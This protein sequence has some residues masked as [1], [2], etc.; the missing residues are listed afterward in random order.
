MIRSLLAAAAVTVAASFPATAE[1]LKFA[2]TDIE[3]LEALQQEF[4]AF[5]AKLE[6]LT[7]HEIDLF[8]VS[9]RTAAVEAL[10]QD[11][12]DLVLTGPAEYVVINELTQ[13]KIV[14]AWQRP[15]YFAQ[16]VTLSDGPIKSV[17]DLKGKTVTFGSVG[18]TSQ[19]LGPAQVLA[20]FGLAY[21]T[22]YQPQII[23]RNVAVEALI[24]G[25][26]QAVGMNEGHLSR[27]REAFPD[28]SFT[29][30]A[31]GRD[32][33]NDILVAR[34]DLD[35][36][37]IADVKAAFV[38][39][40]AELMDAILTGEDNQK[41]KGG[42]FLTKVEDSEYDYVRSMYKTIGVDTNAFVGN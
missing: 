25:D 26:V 30:V 7:G 42:F 23:A 34:S 10:N 14:T 3:G 32:L 35:D 4:G 31:R 8:P 33:P 29:V 16:I 28:T 1:S 37:T 12:V 5:E 17:Q 6:E 18:S 13:A 2:V 40:G 41:Y 36:A 11:K 20:D 24:R 22:D 15:N 38:D 9:S 27:I 19:H 21:N 39:H